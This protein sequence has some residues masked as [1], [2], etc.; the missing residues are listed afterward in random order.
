[1][2]DELDSAH[3]DTLEQ[4]FS[5]SRGN[6]EWR[7][8]LSLLEAVGDVRARHNGKLEVELGG[9]TE[10]FEPPRHKDVDE[11]LLVDVRRMLRRAGFAPDRPR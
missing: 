9:E 4:I 2:S 7:R 8:V 3:R 6:V 11:Q 10:V 1:V 5:H